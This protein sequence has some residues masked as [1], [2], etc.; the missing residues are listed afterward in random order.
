MKPMTAMLLAST[1]T[2]FSAQGSAEVLL[3]DAIAEAPEN[4]AQGLPR[5]NTGL[6]METVWERFGKPQSELPAVGTPPITRWVYGDFTV[7]FEHDRVIN[8]VV[9]R[10]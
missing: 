9:H 4:S 7:Y 2:L 10:P 8:T 1:I 3:I 6:S 5:P